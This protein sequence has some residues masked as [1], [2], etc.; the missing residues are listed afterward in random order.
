MI[1]ESVHSK[2]M[3]EEMLRDKSENFWI[4]NILQLGVIWDSGWKGELKNYVTLE[5]GKKTTCW[6]CRQKKLKKSLEFRFSD[7]LHF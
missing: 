6:C 4:L 3:V 7:P 2:D 5:L 1:M